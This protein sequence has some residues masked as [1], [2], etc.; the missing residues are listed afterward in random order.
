MIKASPYRIRRIVNTDGDIRLLDPNEPDQ[1]N[2]KFSVYETT[3]YGNFDTWL[4]DFDTFIAAAAY[5]SLL[6]TAVFVVMI[7][8]LETDFSGAVYLQDAMSYMHACDMAEDY[9]KWLSRKGGK[10]SIDAIHIVPEAN[11]D[12]IKQYVP[13]LGQ[14][15][16]Q[17]CSTE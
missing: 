11:V 9:A 15:D 13:S 5:T 7:R 17:D 1:P 8:H 3:H 14:Q 10:F 6:D 4:E 2:M 16:F 12:I